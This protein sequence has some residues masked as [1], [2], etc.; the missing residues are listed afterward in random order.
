MLYSTQPIV[1]A[2]IEENDSMLNISNFPWAEF[3]LTEERV[4]Y[5]RDTLALKRRKRDTGIMRYRFELVTIPMPFS[6][7]RSLKAQ[8]SRAVNDTLSFIHPRYS[9]TQGFEPNSGIQVSGSIAAGV[10]NISLTSVDSW[11]LMAG[12]LIQPSDDT[13][14]YEVA[15][16]TATGVGVK[17]VKLTSLIRNPLVDGSDMTVNDVVFFLESDGVIEIATDAS[18]GQE[19]EI[20]LNVV[21]KL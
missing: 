1:V 16:D 17:S 4:L 21:E 11:Q 14:V 6:Q 20:T 5:V 18:D 12:D 10:D 7:G 3:N 15:E 19:I 9:Y 2:A 8:L 13:K